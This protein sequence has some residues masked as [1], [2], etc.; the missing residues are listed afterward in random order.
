MEINGDQQCTICIGSSV[1]PRRNL[2]T[3]YQARARHTEQDLENPESYKIILVFFRQR[4]GATAVSDYDRH[5]F[6]HSN[7]VNICSRRMLTA[8]WDTFALSLSKMDALV[9]LDCNEI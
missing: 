6:H 5:M 9:K 2:V 7:S 8:V 4:W 1:V 3:W